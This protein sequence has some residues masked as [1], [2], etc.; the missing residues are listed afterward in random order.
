MAKFWRS[1]GFRPVVGQ[2]VEHSKLHQ[3]TEAKDEADGNIEIQG[4]DIG[5]TWEI[6]SGK[7]AQCGH[8][9]YR[10]Y[11]CESTVMEVG[12]ATNPYITLLKGPSRRQFCVHLYVLP[13]YL[14]RFWLGQSLS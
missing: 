9:E 6:L 8:G 10:G 13:T 14:K 2:K 3:S 5:D 12:S 1:T 11:S 7:G 4:C